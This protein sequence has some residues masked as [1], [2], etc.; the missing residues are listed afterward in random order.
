MCQAG[1]G[2]VTIQQLP[3]ASSSCPGCEQLKIASLRGNGN[4]IAL[5]APKQLRKHWRRAHKSS[6]TRTA[7]LLRR[8][9]PLNGH[10]VHDL[11]VSLR[12]ARLL[13]Q[14]C[15][16]RHDRQCVKNF[17][18]AARTAMD[19]F[20][21]PRDADVALDWAKHMHASPALLTHLLRERAKQCHRAEK[22]LKRLK[23]ELRVSK[24]KFMGKEDPE[25]LS[26]RFNRWIG[27]ISARCKESIQR[28]DQLSVAELHALRRD[29]RRWRYLRELVATA[30]PVARDRIVSALVAAQESLGAIQDTEV[31]L[32]QIKSCGRSREVIKFKQVLRQELELNRLEALEEM[33]KLK[34]HP[35]FKL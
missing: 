23:P 14:L 5:M 24:L 4:R 22:V 3:G 30:R 2:I 17:R 29:F 11:R 1:G 26:R 10:A 25:K 16:K 21:P 18:A 6:L 32:Q 13:L 34:R 19:A 27:G 31:I 15:G 20:A 28:A 12:R 35:A 7:E 9:G 33:S 8:R